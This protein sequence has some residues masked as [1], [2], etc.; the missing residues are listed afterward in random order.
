M[1]NLLAADFYKL[2][3][4]KSFYICLGI[5]AAVVAYIIIDFGSSSHMKEQL[6]PNTFHWI[7]MIFKEKAFLPY[8]MPVLQ[9]IFITMLITSEYNMGIIKDSVSLGFSRT[10]IYMSKLITISVGS[11]FMMFIAILFTVITSTFVFGIYG[12][13]S[14]SDLLLACRMISIQAL[15][16]TAYGSIFLMI[17][18]LIKNIG[19][20]MAFTI[21]SSLILGSLSSI[22]GNSYV[23][24]ILLLM[25]FSPVAMPHPQ[26]KDIWIAI[27]A[28][29]AYLILCSGV[30]GFTFKKQDIK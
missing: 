6:S 27:A 17:A 29:L 28:A 7:Y 5:L 19:G 12:S 22:I 24:R 16:Y 25:N 8:F 26:V 23:G 4:C 10:K 13:F 21:F 30:G 9:A 18:V 1:L 11:I 15:L 3:R 14:M 20:T 2:R